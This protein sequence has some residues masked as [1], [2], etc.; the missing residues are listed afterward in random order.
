[1]KAFDCVVGK[2]KHCR[3]LIKRYQ[4]QFLMRRFLDTEYFDEEHVITKDDKVCNWCTHASR[5]PDLRRAGDGR[6]CYGQGTEC[7]ADCKLTSKGALVC[8]GDKSSLCAGCQQRRRVAS[9]HLDKRSKKWQAQG[10]VGDKHVFLGSHADEEDAARAVAAFLHDGTRPPT[11]Q[12]SSQ[13]SQHRG[14]SWFARQRKWRAEVQVKGKRV[15]LGHYADEEDAAR[16][17]TKFLN[18]GS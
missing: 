2:P 7:M 16:A 9:A 15:F 12:P 14:V 18:S 1:M 3:D 6:F 13:H 4:D 11:R 8:Y 5:S 10:R 17:V